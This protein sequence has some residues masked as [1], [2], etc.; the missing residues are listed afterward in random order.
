[1]TEMVLVCS[2]LAIFLDTFAPCHESYTWN[3]IYEYRTGNQYSTFECRLMVLPRGAK[4]DS[5]VGPRII[6]Q[7]QQHNKTSLTSTKTEFGRP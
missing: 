6:D 3:R 2:F 5:R 1:M 7:L 4:T